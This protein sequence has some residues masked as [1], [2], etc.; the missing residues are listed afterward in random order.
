MCG[1]SLSSD[2]NSTPN[3]S[4]RKEFSSHPRNI[5]NWRRNRNEDG[6]GDASSSGLGS[7]EGWRGNS[8]TGGSFA[9]THRWGI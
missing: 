1:I 7:T 5:E 2:W 3:S 8:S 6:S 9:A 4:P